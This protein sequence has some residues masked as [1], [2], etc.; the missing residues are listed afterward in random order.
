MRPSYARTGLVSFTTAQMPCVSGE[1]EGAFVG[2]GRR[3]AG[4]GRRAAGG[5]R[6]AAGGG[7]R[8][9]GG[10]PRRGPGGQGSIPGRRR[11][12]PAGSP[13]KTKSGPMW[14]TATTRANVASRNDRNAPVSSREMVDWFVRVRQ[15]SCCCVR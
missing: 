2:G 14:S 10:G 15:A 11:V 12:A 9:A 8:A 3:A 1:Y 7:R 13:G 5:G 6:R 4:G